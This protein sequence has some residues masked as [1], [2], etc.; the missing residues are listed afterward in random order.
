MK[1]NSVFSEIDLSKKNI[2]KSKILNRE[3]RRDMRHI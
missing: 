1:R 2:D 3:M